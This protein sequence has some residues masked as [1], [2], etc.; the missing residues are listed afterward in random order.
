MRC[1]RQQNGCNEVFYPTLSLSLLAPE[2]EP[3]ACGT[4]RGGGDPLG[5]RGEGDETA[6]EGQRSAMMLR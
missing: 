6:N 5:L 4:G 2:Q 1:G 3:Q